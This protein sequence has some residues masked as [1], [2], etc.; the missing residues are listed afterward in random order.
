MRTYKPSNENAK[1][2]RCRKNWKAFAKMHKQQPYENACEIAGENTKK[3]HEKSEENAGV[4]ALKKGKRA[5]ATALLT[6]AIV[7]NT[8]TNCGE[9]PQQGAN[10]PADIKVAD[11]SDSADKGRPSDTNVD[12]VSSDGGALPDTDVDDVSSDG[13]A[14]PDTDVDDISSDGGAL[15]D[16]NVDDISSDG[17]ALPDTDVDDVSSDGGALP[18]IDVKDVN[19]EDVSDAGDVL[20]SDTGGVPD[21]SVI[22]RCELSDRTYD[23]FPF[24][25][26]MKD[27]NRQIMYETYGYVDGYFPDGGYT[28]IDKLL[29]QVRTEFGG[30]LTIKAYGHATALFFFINWSRKFFNLYEVTENSITL[31]KEIIYNGRL[32]VKER[33]VVPDNS[34]NKIEIE[35]ISEGTNGQP[36]VAVIK[37]VDSTNTEVAKGTINSGELGK[38]GNYFIRI[39]SVEIDP[40]YP[41]ISTAEI[42][43]VSA[44]ITLV[45]GKVFEKGKK[46]DWDYEYIFTTNRNDGGVTEW[47]VKYNYTWNPSSTSE[48]E[49][50]GDY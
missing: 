50:V 25:N 43:V 44:P 40:N 27:G 35:S 4:S 23:D 49:S 31:Y 48:D 45:E 38:I 2:E 7:F 3:P 30:P 12:D 29:V 32:F 46:G 28:C 5:L 22:D 11:V 26:V 18:D 9:N 24:L 37:V 34:G 36:P 17:G 19:S 20:D 14:L 21:T 6:A 13:G 39:Y 16:N 42:A 10:S 33:L 15:P 1:I 8:L 47:Y 41:G